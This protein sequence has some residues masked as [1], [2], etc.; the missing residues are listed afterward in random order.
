M[1]DHICRIDENLLH[2]TAGPYIGVNRTTLTMRRS[3]PV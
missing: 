1:Q 3:L 2:R